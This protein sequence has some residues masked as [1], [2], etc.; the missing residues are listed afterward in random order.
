MK[1]YKMTCLRVRW[2]PTRYWMWDRSP[3]KIL[4]I[5]NT[6]IMCSLRRGGKCSKMKRSTGTNS[7]S[8]SS[9][10]RSIPTSRNTTL[11]NSRRN[12]SRIG[13]S[14]STS[15][16]YPSLITFERIAGSSVSPL[17]YLLCPKYVHSF[18]TYTKRIS[19]TS[20]KC[21]TF[22]SPRDYSSKYKAFR[23]HIL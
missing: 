12:K 22:T 17:N 10:P 23:R 20:S 14:S 15:R 13:C 18:N 8:W 19:D 21:A 6:R 4:T 1:I 7:I 5:S 16:K 9:S 3:T 11:L 2:L